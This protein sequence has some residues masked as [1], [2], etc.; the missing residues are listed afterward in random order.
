MSGK[1][2]TVCQPYDPHRSTGSRAESSLNWM[3]WQ[4]LPT[5]HLRDPTPN[6]SMVSF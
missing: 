6:R 4:P 3:V 1:N 2:S 5:E